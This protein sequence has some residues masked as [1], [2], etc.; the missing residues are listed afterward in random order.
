MSIKNNKKD[1]QEKKLHICQFCFKHVNNP[2]YCRATKLYVNR[3]KEACNLF[4]SKP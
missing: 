3:K 2:S 1:N 4:K